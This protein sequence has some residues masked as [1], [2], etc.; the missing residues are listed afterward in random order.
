MLNETVKSGLTL[1]GSGRGCHAYSCRIRPWAQW[2]REFYLK[3]LY[4]DFRDIS[5]IGSRLPE[6]PADCRDPPTFPLVPPRGAQFRG[7]YPIS[8]K[9]LDS[10]GVACRD[11]RCIRSCFPWASRV[12]GENSATEP[13]MLDEASGRGCHTHSCGIWP[14]AQWGWEFYLKML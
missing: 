14:W 8:V 12:A 10:Y 2:G 5:C 9:C 4:S 11:F 6:G 7:K 13:P 1:A 3:T